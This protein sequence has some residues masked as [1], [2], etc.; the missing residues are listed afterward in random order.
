MS[1]NVGKATEGLENELWRKWSDGKVWEWALLMGEPPMPYLTSPYRYIYVSHASRALESLGLSG[2][3]ITCGSHTYF[4]DHTRTWRASSDEWSAQY[5]RPPPRQHECAR[6]D[7]PFTHPFIP[8]RRIWK[9]EYDG[10]IIF[11]DLETFLLQVRKKKTLK[12]KTSPRKV[13]P[14]GDRTRA[15]CVTDAHATACRMD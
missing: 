7:R 14:T 5:R 8:T 4:F 15:R 3:A 6:W 1:C 11:G 9:D 2:E 10:Q 12:K 13:V